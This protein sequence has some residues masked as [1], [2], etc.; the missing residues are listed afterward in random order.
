[1]M[2]PHLSAV[3]ADEGRASRQFMADLLRAAGMRDIR[4]TGDS[5]AA[6]AEIQTRPPGLLLL[7]CAKPERCLIAL[8]RIRAMQIDAIRKLPVIVVTAQP[9]KAL[10]QAV[11]DA[12][13]SEILVKPFAAPSFFARISAAVLSPRA[14]IDVDGFV[15][16]DRRRA[17][18]LDYAGPFRRATDLTPDILEIA[19]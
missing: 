7:D 8:G 2:L 17:P 16:P 12:G 19:C 3:I 11:R 18:L 6:F 13:A 15:G 1:M 10:A 14:F 5:D 4:I 9:T